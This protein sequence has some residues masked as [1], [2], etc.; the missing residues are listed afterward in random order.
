MRER[1]VRKSRAGA[2]HDGGAKTARKMRIRSTTTIAN[3]VAGPAPRILSERE[4]LHLQTPAECGRETCRS[5]ATNSPR[6]GSA[7]D[8]FKEIHRL[9]EYN[10]ISAP[11]SSGRGEPRVPRGYL[12]AFGGYSDVPDMGTM[13]RPLIT[14]AICITPSVEAIHENMTE[15]VCTRELGFSQIF[16]DRGDQESSARMGI[17]ATISLD[18]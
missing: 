3:R 15:E 9:S 6:C 2:L 8:F 11:E 5:A 4:R 13:T 14:D 1:T 17:L 12:K 10:T 16:A 18:P 7:T